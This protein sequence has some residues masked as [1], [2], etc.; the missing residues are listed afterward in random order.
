MFHLI[1]FSNFSK[2]IEYYS[3]Q[4]AII[5]LYIIT[6]RSNTKHRTCPISHIAVHSAICLTV[7]CMSQHFPTGKLDWDERIYACI[8]TAFLSRSQTLKGF[9][10]LNISKI[11][12]QQLWNVFVLIWIHFYCDSKYCTAIFY[13]FGI[14]FPSNILWQVLNYRLQYCVESVIINVTMNGCSIN[15]KHIM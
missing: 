12:T 3:M 13:N 1:T 9:Y 6:D 14:F 2:I 4:T 11:C 5:H 10:I 7:P 15:F 8:A